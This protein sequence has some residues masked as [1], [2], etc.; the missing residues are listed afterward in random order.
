MKERPLRRIGEMAAEVVRDLVVEEAPLALF[1]HSLGALVAFETARELRRLGKG[2]VLALFVSA[3]RAPRSC[4]RTGPVGELTDRELIERLRGWNGT[5]AVVLEDPELVRLFLPVIRGDLSAL[6][7]YEYESREPLGCPIIAFA[8]DRDPLVPGGEIDGWRAET[9]GAFRKHVVS[10][11]HFFL[12][13]PESFLPALRG[14][15]EILG[16]TLPSPTLRRAEG[17]NGRI[18]DGC[19]D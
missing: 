6:E 3:A 17:S 1:G 11:D 7:R 2:R 13:A 15:L 16:A 19:G 12:H 18:F 9:C 8:G 4:S 10:G 5:P 14:E